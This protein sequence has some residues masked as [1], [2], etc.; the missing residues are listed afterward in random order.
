MCGWVRG[1]GGWGGM[2][3]FWMLKEDRKWVVGVWRLGGRVGEA[4]FRCA[5][6]DARA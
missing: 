4:S 2:G 5:R 1:C 3:V 6:Q